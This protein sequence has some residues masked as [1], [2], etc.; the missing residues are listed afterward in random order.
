M[1][2]TILIPDDGECYAVMRRPCR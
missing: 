2:R 1:N